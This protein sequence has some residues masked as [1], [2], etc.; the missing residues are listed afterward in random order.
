ML[1]DF[2]QSFRNELLLLNFIS[3]ESVYSYNAQLLLFS[4]KPDAPSD[5]FN[6]LARCFLV[7]ANTFPLEGIDI[8][9]S[10]TGI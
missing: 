10:D 1:A 3:N 7:T 4:R 5:M 6:L 8:F 2:F 9:G